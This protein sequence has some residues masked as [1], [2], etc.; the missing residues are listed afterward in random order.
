[1]INKYLWVVFVLSLAGYGC[2]SLHPRADSPKLAIT[3]PVV[4]LKPMGMPANADSVILS[5]VVHNYSDTVQRFCKWDTPFEPLLGKYL[6]VRDKSGEEAAYRGAMARRVMPPPAESYINVNPYDSV[7][8]TFN[9]AKG[10]AIKPGKYTISYTATGLSGI[11]PG[12]KLKITVP[13]E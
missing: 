10:Y 2:K 12:N 7:S 13:G 11:Q 9:L 6:S 5:F 1:M 3:G 4:T 8:A